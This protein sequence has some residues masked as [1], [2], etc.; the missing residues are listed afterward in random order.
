[1][2]TALITGATAGLGRS[3]AEALA[4]EG[5][6]LVLVARSETALKE[7]ADELRASYGTESEVLAADLATDEGCAAVCSRLGAD[8]AVDLLV[9]NA[10]IGYER[11]FLNNGP[12]AEERL[13]D[14]NVRAVLRLTEAALTAMTARRRGQVLNVASVAGIGPSWLSS[15]YPAS[16]AW[17]ISFTES[18]AWSRQVRDAGIRMTALLPG[19]TRTEF[20]R[21]AGIPTTFPPPWLWLDADQVVRTALRDLRRGKVVS[22]PSLRYKAATWALR[23]LPRPLTRQ[24]AWDI[25]A[26]QHR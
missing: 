23:H 19:Y 17:V 11:P 18:L 6:R 21:R 12:R 9:N 13:L 8:P 10:G 7:T 4:R 15:T 20:H 24:G 14:L 5:H 25:S 22:V 26:H 2:P 16:K 1:M 3:F